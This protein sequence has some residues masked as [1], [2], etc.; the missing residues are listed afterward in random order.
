[1]LDMSWPP[2]ASSSCHTC[3]KLFS[4]LFAE[5]KHVVQ[6]CLMFLFGICSSLT[7]HNT[8][9]LFQLKF[10]AKELQRSSKKCDK[11]E[12]TEKLKVKKVSCSTE[13]NCG[14]GTLREPVGCCWPQRSFPEPL[15]F[16]V[17]FRPSR[18][19]TWRWR[20]S[21]PRMPSDRRTSLWTSS[22]WALG[23]MLWQ[24]GFK[25]Q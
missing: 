13:S 4:E 22:G 21:M 23:W 11:E 19:G 9:H 7:S 15:Y 14:D 12:K 3:T 2:T 5:L 16:C 1:M 18:R 8:E 6:D 25:P 20:G 10:T 24:Q 17:V